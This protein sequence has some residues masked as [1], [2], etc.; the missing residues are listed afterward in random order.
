MELPF[1]F[2]TAELGGFNYTKD[3]L[4]LA[5][6]MV[7]YWTNFAHY[8]NPNGQFL[9]AG[10]WTKPRSLVDWP[11]YYSEEESDCLRFKTPQS[12]VSL[13]CRCCLP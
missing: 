1:V 9:K 4:L 8:G 10:G 12:E 5:D 2:H 13:L 6:A 3:E 7:T 11:P